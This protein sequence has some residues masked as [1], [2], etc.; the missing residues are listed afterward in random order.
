DY[1]NASSTLLMDVRTK[2]WSAAM[3]EAFGIEATRLARLDT[4]MRPLGT[5]RPALAETLGLKRTTLVMVGCGDE[6]A[7]SLGAG[8]IRP[9]LVGDIAGTAEPVCSASTRPVFDSTH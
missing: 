6:H 4:A 2:T 7:A 5:L 9:G 1:S 3:C 8:V